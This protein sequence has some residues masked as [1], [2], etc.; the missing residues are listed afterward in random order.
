M[1]SKSTFWHYVLSVRLVEF[2]RLTMHIWRGCRETG[3]LINCGWESK[4]ISLHGGKSGTLNEIMH[5]LFELGIILVGIYPEI[6]THKYETL[7]IRLFIV[8]LFVLRR[9]WSQ[10]KCSFTEDMLN[11]LWYSHTRENTQCKRKW[12][13]R[14]WFPGYVKSKR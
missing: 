12:N 11:H 7:V 5:L 6:R 1:Q 8:M 10:L 13:D 9:P 3:T 2:K 4:M 14:K